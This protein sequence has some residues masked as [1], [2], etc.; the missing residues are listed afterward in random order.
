VTVRP[1][2]FPLTAKASPRPP[3]RSP[4]YLPPAVGLAP[5]P[6]RLVGSTAVPL[7]VAAAAASPAATLAAAATPATMPAPAAP[8]TGETA[9]AAPPDFM[10]RAN[11]L[12]ATQIPRIAQRAER[13][14]L[15]V[16]V[17]AAHADEDGSN[18][19]EVRLAAGAIRLAPDDPQLTRTAVRESRQFHEGA[20]IALQRGDFA[21]AVGLQTRAFGANPI[22]AEIV[23]TLAHMRL[24]QTPSQ[25]EAAR[26]LALHALTLQ[27]WKY[28]S[29]R[30][31]DWNT[32]AIASALTGHDRDARNAWL[33]ALALAGG[34]ERQCRAAIDAYALYGE[35]L[36]LP[37]EAML[38]RANAGGRSPRSRLCE[39]PPHWSTSAR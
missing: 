38:Y 11:E 23:G 35:S 14:V 28:P 27:D 4:I 6:G 37:V 33:V 12:L 9:I 29:G 30:I 10:L 24:R 21:E 26:R 34:S 25:P 19:D 15:R 36:R 31:E 8:P 5:L 22:D 32:F 39:W 2:A 16:L 13:M 3:S 18:D 1:A 20:R 7:T 17:A